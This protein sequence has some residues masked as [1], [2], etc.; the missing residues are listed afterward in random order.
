[1]EIQAAIAKVDRF[2]SIEEGDKVEIIERPKGG[3]SIILAEGKLE[4]RRSKAVTMKAVHT[5]LNLI[6]EG[7]H[8]GAASRAVLSNLQVEHSGKV[9]LSLSLISCDYESGTVVITKNN[10]LPVVILQEGQVNFLNLDQDQDLL[11][12][13]PVVFQFPLEK[14][15]TF[16]LMS[17]GIFSAGEQTHQTLDLHEIMES[18]IED[19]L[20]SV[21]EMTEFVLQQ[22]ISRDIGRPNDD[23]SVVAVRIAPGAESDFRKVSLRIPI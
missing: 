18:L 5:V 8:D 11:A 23:M 14:E 2:S 10:P 16:F 22:A 12:E 4:H 9:D 1:M 19:D 21:E 20:P 13:N 6:S 15:M 7:I 17:D 3:F